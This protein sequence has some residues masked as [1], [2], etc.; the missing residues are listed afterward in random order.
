MREYC[1]ATRDGAHLQHVTLIEEAHRVMAATSHAANREVSADTRAQAVS[2]FSD[3]LSEVRAF[4]EGLIIAEQ[5]PGRLAEDA[6]KNTN[7]KIVHRLPGQDDREAVGSTMNLGEEQASFLTKL[8]AGQAA[9]F[10]EGYER[11]TFVTVPNYKDDHDLPGRVLDARVQEKMGQFYHASGELWL[12]YDGCR[13]CQQV[14]RHRN[15][16]AS[17]VYEVSARDNLNRG[18]WQYEQA[19]LGG[20]SEA[21]WKKLVEAC[22]EAIGP[23]GLA[24]N[25]H[26]GYCYLVHLLTFPAT[27]DMAAKFRSVWPR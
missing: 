8:P 25:P 20:D 2:M 9:F 1:R 6:L 11:P 23:L 7:T 21:G 5:I 17:A 13:Y 26:A 19:R 24:R 4:G 12:P 10:R 14:C 22:R 18:L 16:I 27:A 3:T 15:R